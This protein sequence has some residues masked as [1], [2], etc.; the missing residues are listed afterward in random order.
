MDDSHDTRSTLEQISD[1]LAMYKAATMGMEGEDAPGLGQVAEMLSDYFEEAVEA[2]R[3]GEPLAWVN[4]GVM[5]ELF[6]A[7]DIVP[8]IIDVV[9]GLVAPTPNAMRYIDIAEEQIPDYICSNNKVLLGAML[10][11]DIAAPDM[12]I[13]PSQPCDSNL[14][15]YP[16]I[17]E[18]FNSPYFCIDVPYFRREK[19]IQF[20]AGELERLV[21]FLEQTTGRKLDYDRLRRAMEY[22]NQAHE[23]YQ[24]ISALREAVPCP[25]MSLDTLAEYPAVLSLAGRPELVDYLKGRYEITRARVDRGEGW[26]PAE[27]EKIRLVW[28]Y[29]A[30]AFDLFVFMWLE[31]EHGAVSV[32]NMNSNFVMGPVKDIGSTKSILRGLAEKVMQLPMTRECGGPWENYIDS[33]IDLCRRYKAD[34]AVLAGHVAC[35]ANWAIMKLVKDKMLEELGIPTLVL[36]VDLFDERITASEAIQEQFDNF[37]QAVL[38]K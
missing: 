35:K 29:G 9:T 23:I 30:P 13:H 38:K 15:T 4:F 27:E 7:M 32:A 14:A 8:V 21:T 5:T 25:Y 28:I 36:E 16:V 6:W 3:K 19:D 20:V 33:S 2:K 11:G 34:A 12:I 37:F 17:A 26:L 18:T 10:A 22:S 24:K 1:S 31:N